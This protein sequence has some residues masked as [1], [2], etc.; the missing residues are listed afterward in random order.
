MEL[1]YKLIEQLLTRVS[2]PFIIIMLLIVSW[3]FFVLYRKDQALTIINETLSDMRENQSSI[4]T[5][6]EVLVYGRRKDHG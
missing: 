2:D 4:L 5:L 6:I 3:L 1:P